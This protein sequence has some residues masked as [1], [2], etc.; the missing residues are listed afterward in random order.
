MNVNVFRTKVLIRDTSF[1][2]PTG[3]GT[4]ILHGR[5]SRAKVSPLAV[6][7]K[8]LHFLSYF[9]TLRIGPSPGIEPATSRS[10]VSAL[11]TELILPQLNSN[12]VRFIQG[13]VKI[14]PAHDHNDYGV[15]QRHN[16]SFVTMIDDN[17]NIKDVK[18]FYPEF[19][20]FAVSFQIG[21]WQ[22]Y[23]CSANK[24]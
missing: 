12:F 5:L 16:L 14:T 6:Q 2:F 15:G 20:H 18:D 22:P 4:A 23:Y 24:L 1:T 11:S 17:G 13:A 10:A 19:Q 7:R 8:Y 21:P 9:K 3:D